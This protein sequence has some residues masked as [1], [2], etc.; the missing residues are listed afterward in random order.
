MKK[1]KRFSTN[2]QR[3]I[4]TAHILTWSKCGWIVGQ[5]TIAP[6]PTSNSLFQQEQPQMVKSCLYSHRDILTS[7]QA[8]STM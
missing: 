7:P 6:P 3:V 5:A 4:D 8:V 2:P 1:N